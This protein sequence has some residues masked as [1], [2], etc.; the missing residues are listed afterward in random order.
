MITRLGKYEI[1][2][3]LGRGAMG[4][5]YEGFDPLIARVVAL[6]TIR[7]DQLATEDAA[8]LV[9]RFR[10]E[11]QAAGRLAHPN[12]VSIYDFGEDGG[13]W[14]I[15]MELVKG[16]ELKERFDAGERF[17]TADT[18]RIME[19]ILAALGYS[20]RQGV[21]HRDVKPAN[22]FL[23]PDGTVKVADFGIAHIESSNLTQVGTVLGTPN[24][25]SPEQIL[26]L[27]VDGRS[28]LFAAGVILYQFLT[29]ERPFT[30]SATTTVQKVLKEDPLPPS[31]LNVQVRPA[32][33]AVVR[34]ALAKR[35]EERFADADE[36]AAALRAAATTES[37]AGADATMAFRANAQGI[38]ADS[39]VAVKPAPTATPP[40]TDSTPGTT[41][42]R[43]RRVPAV[44]IAAAFAAV[45]IGA[46]IWLLL[47][48]PQGEAAKAVTAPAAPATVTAGTA[49]S[50]P[51]S[52]APNAPPSLP[53]G[54]MLISAV[55]VIDPA[56]P[57][58]RSDDSVRQS[59]VR[60]ASQEQLVEKALGLFIDTESLARNYD[61][62]NDRLLSRSG[63][64]IT[65]VVR[66]SEA[67]VG[68]D[69]LLTV[70]TEA[71]VDVK[72]LQKAVNQ[73][74]RDERIA[75]IRA[76]GDPRISVRILVRTDSAPDAPSRPSPIAENIIKAEIK[77]FGFRTWSDDEPA[78]AN[79]AKS[80]DFAITGEVTLRKLS[81]RLEASG[82][83]INKYVVASATVKC[84]DRETGE[85]I[86]HNTVLPKGG[87]SEPS[88]DE[89]LKAI[90]T[91]MAKEFSRDFFLEHL[92]TAGQPVQ[93]QV[94]GVPDAIADAVLVRELA[95]L[96]AVISIAPHA[97]P[98]PRTYD[99][100][101]AGAGPLGERVA[102]DVL[103]PL[104]AKLGQD[105][106]RLGA[107]AGDQVGIALDA[108][109][110]DAA[111]LS[112]LESYPPAWLYAVPPGRQKSVTTNPETLRKLT[113]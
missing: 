43:T 35:P 54:T 19:Q 23:L 39:T 50:T 62:I 7:A 73:M 82:L 95:G 112:R 41:T 113:I 63:S 101:L 94:A 87:G 86:Y 4:V 67:R 40:P 8:G 69:G 1:R 33:D 13:A 111:V 64:F 65:R 52:P 15:A 74:S 22:I 42:A 83:V 2:R 27:P 85:E 53:P 96:P 77:S 12:I 47:P 90:G 11:A 31:I 18:V 89:A 103:K 51:P 3:E 97:R 91:R 59:E 84:V 17:T 78:A 49:A 70:T 28:D 21:V 98:G 108:R 88:E 104:N 79:G 71:V 30:G 57:R 81:V 102:H 34:R 105:C 93:L 38:A 106:F 66:E 32:F 25:M 46:G 58:F 107:V 75:F 36:F 20:H 110:T 45:A 56:D 24:Y 92:V 29:G 5:V 37:A 60:K 6:K 9:A 61:A 14:F 76:R 48:R 80:A 44:A 68:K 100:G 72:A 55:G 26:G 109:C 10:N 16:R 99:V